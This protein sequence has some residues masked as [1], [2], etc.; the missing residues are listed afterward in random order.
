MHQPTLVIL[1]AGMGSRYGGLKQIDPVDEYGNIIIDYSIF[2][3]L[4]AG[5]SRVVCIIKKEI[6]RDFHEVIGP[7]IAKRAE[8]VYAY[9]EL[10]K[11]P[12]GFSVPEGRSKPWGTAHALLCCRDVVD[13]PFAVINADDYYGRSAYS[14]IYS[15]LSAPHAPGEYAMVGYSV[16]NTLT[17][18]GTVTRGVCAVDAN[19]YLQ[20]IKECSGI[21]KYA[22]GGMYEENGREIFIP[23]GTPVSMNLWGF[24]P[25]LFSGL[26]AGFPPFL[27]NGLKENP[28]KC[29]YLLP[30]AVHD[31]ISAKE[32]SVKM[33]KS[34][35]SWFGVTYK[36]DMPAVRAAIRA[37]KDQ[38]LYKERLWED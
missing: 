5:F 28:L 22:H 18:H 21:R 38:G 9:Q 14:A 24:D 2:D 37:L 12:Q 35:D 20:N 6:E 16:E 19:G 25:S 13:G 30:T 15:Y 26:A 32:A 11:L 27:E 31:L 36:E 23:K 3:A 17:D 34:E 1:A 33:L 4:Q 29:E 8:L 7:R 10:D